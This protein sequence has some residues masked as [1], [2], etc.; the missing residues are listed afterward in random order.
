MKNIINLEKLEELPP[1]IRKLII[2]PEINKVPFDSLNEGNIEKAVNYVKTKTVFDLLN[3]PIL[4]ERENK[5][6]DN[7][8]ILVFCQPS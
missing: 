6:P 1:S 7:P 2:K 5:L 8:I 4:G 3:A